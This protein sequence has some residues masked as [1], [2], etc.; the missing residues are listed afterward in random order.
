MTESE[1]WKDVAGYEGLYQVSDKGRIYSVERIDSRGHRRRGRVLKPVNN[2]HGY[3]QVGL[4]KGG[5]RKRKLMHRL[6]ADAFIPNPKGFL[7]INH[8]DENKLNNRVENLEWC[9]REHNINYGTRTEKTSKKVR[10][11][12]IKTGEVVTFNSTREAGRKG[13]NQGN[14]SMAC[15]GTHKTRTGKLVGG[16]G[17]TYQGY[18][19]SYEEAEGNVSKRVS[20]TT[21]T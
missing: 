12:E 16:D 15:R 9:T 21:R 7:E 3:L 11:V 19:W 1:I 10:A 13:Y 20:I 17:C 4:C 8:K 18:R 5:T 6:V 2:G 14:V